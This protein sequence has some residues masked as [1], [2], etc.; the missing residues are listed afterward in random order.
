MIDIE[1]KINGICCK[2]CKKFTDNKCTNIDSDY[3]ED[4]KEIMIEIAM[5]KFKE[6]G[7]VYMKH[8]AENINDYYICED[9]IEI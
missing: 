1:N 3:Y 8:W 2:N 4:D 6:T 5:V 7:D 9:F